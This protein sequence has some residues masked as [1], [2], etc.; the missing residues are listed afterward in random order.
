MG[1]A[2]DDI[3]LREWSARVRFARIAFGWPDAALVVRAHPGGASLA[4]AAPLDQLLTATEVNEWA[5]LASLVSLSRV[6]SAGCHAPGHAAAWDQNL[7]LGTIGAYSRAERNP[8]L[9]V[10]AQ[11]AQD[12]RLIALFD[13]HLLSVGVGAGSQTWTLA[14]LPDPTDVDWRGLK[15]A[16][17][18][19]V[20]GSNGKTTTTRLLAA[21]ARARGWRTSY[22]CTDGV[23]VDSTVLAAGDYSGPAGARVAVRAA[24][25]EAAILETARG[26]LLRR[27]LAVQYADVAIVTNVSDDHFGE[28]GVHSLDDLADVKLSIAQALGDEGTLVLN[29]DDPCLV[30]RADGLGVPLAWF[31]AD[32]DAPLLEAHRA[33]GGATCGVRD[34]HL[35]LQHGTGSHDL[36]AVDAMPLS[37]NGSARYNVANIAAA[38]LA[39]NAMGIA[40]ALMREV[41]AH[42]GRERGD[43]PGRLQH[44][45]F[46]GVAI[47]VDYAHNPDG[48]RG[49]LAVATQNRPG[50]LGLLLGQ[51]GNREDTEIREL[52]DA[53]AGFNPDLI[54]LKDLGDMLRG[55]ARG[56]VPAILRDE[57]AQCGLHGTS[58]VERL[59]EYEA[60]GSMLAWARNGDTLVLPVHGSS[61]KL[62]VGALLDGLQSS[63]W[64][65]G[66]PLPGG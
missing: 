24:G 31:A 8:R 14:N 12:R 17:V 15:N 11:A 51:A 26:G 43:N 16:P 64:I 33:R 57:L 66:S 19:L 46:G 37:F 35:L 10:L 41:L 32:A 22:T 58:V 5:L 55:R 29:A 27:G 44:W 7:A 45:S 21:F 56:E 13:D 36:G 50:R 25:V 20:T 34:G 49:L 3:L 6:E 60:V 47:Y 65:A 59:D 61:V 52:A 23:F 63:G 1:V 39:G 53:A 2:V 42:F 54:V 9:E 4:F 30:R 62:K 48:L 40:P 38:A 28:Y 18:A